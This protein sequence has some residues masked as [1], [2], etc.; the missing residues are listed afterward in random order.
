MTYVCILLCVFV[1]Q[2]TDTNQLKSFAEQC[3]DIGMVFS[4]DS[5][6]GCKINCKTEKV[7]GI[8]VSKIFKELIIEDGSPCGRNGNCT[9]GLCHKSK[10][11]DSYNFD[12]NKLCNGELCYNETK[13][14]NSMKNIF[15]FF[16]NIWKSIIDFILMCLKKVSLF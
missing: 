5:N 9:N 16:K 4:Y 3:K 2:F 6:D 15:S 8:N 1:A 13:K 10:K 14:S 12:S 7:H 11:F